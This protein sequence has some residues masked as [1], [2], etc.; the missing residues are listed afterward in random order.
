M[1]LTALWGG[2]LIILLLSMVVMHRTTGLFRGVTIAGTFYLFYIVLI[3]LGS[4]IIYLRHPTPSA[5]TYLFAVW[6]VLLLLPIG[7]AAANGVFRFRPHRALTEYLQRQVRDHL[8]GPSFSL[9]YT[10]VLVF[11]V[12]MSLFY[13][14]SLPTIPFIA[15]LGKAETALELVTLRQ[16][17]TAF[18]QGSFYA[19]SVSFYVLLPFLSM[20]A[21]AK[22]L[23]SRSRRW[24]IIF[25]MTAAAA[26]FMLVA[27]L[28]KAPIVLFGIALLAVY[29]LAS[30]RIDKRAIGLTFAL[31]ATVTIA[32][33][34][35][36]NIG[37]GESPRE[38]LTRVLYGVSNRVFLGQTEPL[39][40]YFEYFPEHHDFVTGR[41]VGKIATLF[42]LDFFP[43]SRQ[44]HSYVYPDKVVEGGSLNTAFIGEVYANFGIIGVVLWVPLVGFVLQVAQILLLRARRNPFN[45][46]LYAFIALAVARLAISNLL[47]V[48]SSWGIGWVLLLAV[49][50]YVGYRFLEQAKRAR[51]TQLGDWAGDAEAHGL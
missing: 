22:Y 20:V 24:L 33:V 16:E 32:F 8:P 44:V 29:G 12:A 25:L 47:R 23:F 11:G 51:S 17:A 41:T 31:L 13:L 40:Y 9:L 10:L 45:I 48:L 34:Y 50:F 1:H 42:N 5:N 21:F 38:R 36:L 35:A 39:Y 37:L 30:P 27:T 15:L 49:Y 6:A 43:D 46:A 18:Y 26:S 19:F 2:W 14:K 3:Y 28:Q 7:I 4:P